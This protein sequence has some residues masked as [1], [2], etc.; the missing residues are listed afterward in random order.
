M[1]SSK[2]TNALLIALV[3]VNG[4]LLIG[5]MTKSVH[6]RCGHNFAM[7]TRFNRRH[8]GEFAFRYREGYFHR[9]HRP[10]NGGELG[11]YNNS[12]PVISK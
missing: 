1:N 10:Y 5:L 2:L 7:H 6:N 8:H 3:A 12:G 9:H 4:I 11:N